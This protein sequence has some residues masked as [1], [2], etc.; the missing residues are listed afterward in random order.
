[1]RSLLTAESNDPSPMPDQERLRCPIDRVVALLHDPVNLQVEGWGGGA[2]E[3]RGPRSVGGRDQLNLDITLERPGAFRLRVLAAVRVIE[4]LADNRLLLAQPLV[5]RSDGGLPAL[6]AFVHLL[7]QDL[8]PERVQQGSR[9]TFYHFAPGV[10]A[11]R[12]HPQSLLEEAC[13]LLHDDDGPPGTSAGVAARV[14]VMYR[15][16]AEPRRLSAAALRVLEEDAVGMQVESAGPSVGE[17]IVIRYPVGGI[18]SG[19]SLTLHG[20]VISAETG[21]WV[22]IALVLDDV[23]RVTWAGELRRLASTC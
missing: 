22:R 20:Q 4:S 13:L 1:M 8:D 15:R 10:P 16:S 6:A 5:A 21:E 2:L 17:D 14:P 23:E 18:R 9:Q 11:P 12:P 7:G 3:L 19:H